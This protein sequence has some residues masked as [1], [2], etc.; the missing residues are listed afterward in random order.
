MHLLK[1]LSSRRRRQQQRID[2]LVD[3][4][5]TL[6]YAGDGTLTAPELMCSYRL[7]HGALEFLI[8]LDRIPGVRIGFYSCGAKLRNE[9]LIQLISASIARRGHSLTQNFAVFSV[10]ARMYG[11]KRLAGLRDGIHLSRAILIDDAGLNIEAGEEA[12]LLKVYAN[13]CFSSALTHAHEVYRARLANNLVR[14]LGIILKSIELSKLSE[15][16]MSV[17]EALKSLQ[18][19]GEKYLHESS[20]AE[21]IYRLGLQAMQDVL[22][23]FRLAMDNSALYPWAALQASEETLFPQE[24]NSIIHDHIEC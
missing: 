16:S 24:L 13:R 17:V 19:D 10:P 9:S 14:A 3:I 5:D 2:V 1:C 8:A 18:W 6:V 20:N 23:D 11:K 7:A 4:D 15:E 21:E 12:N 22:P